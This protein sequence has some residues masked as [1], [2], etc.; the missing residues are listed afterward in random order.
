MS[1]HLHI[2]CLDAP[3]PPSYGGAMD[4]Y[5]KITALAALGKKIILHYF[6]YKKNRNAASLNGYCVEV[7]AYQR[8][9]FINS[10]SLPYMISSRVNRSLINRLNKDRFPVLLEGL[11]CS[12]IIPYLNDTSRVLVRM[13]NEESGYYESLARLEKNIFKKAYYSTEALLLNKYQERLD[14]NIKFACLSET[15]VTILEKEYG[16]TKLHFI[17][18]FI[19]WQSVRSQAGRGDYC[20]YHG[21]MA[22][23]E[24]EAAATWLIR[25]VFSKTGIPFV[26]AGNAI[27][28]SLR[29]AALECKNCRLVYDPP[30]D[31]LNALI[32]DAQI[33]VLPS[34]NTTGVKLKLLHALF[35]G[36]FCL[37]NEQGIRGSQVH[38]G[39]HLAQEAEQ[40]VPLIQNLFEQDFT[41]RH[42]EE[43]HYLEVLYN[44]KINAQKLSALW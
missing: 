5:Y 32:R 9:G 24:N 39:V 19:P 15:D 8:K 25:H 30:D 42:A 16:W 34:K 17:P 7:H 33:N 6:D 3:S 31:E 13:H 14:R 27:S 41:R 37:S 1:D 20:L 28:K 10:F 43:R 36:R 38:S 18:C 29:A 2:V 22:V 40:W 26:V 44:N 11:H 21:N 23:P 35:E 12:G 4:M